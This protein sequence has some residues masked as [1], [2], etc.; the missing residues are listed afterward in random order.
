M[1]PF[2]AAALALL[3]FL[4]VVDSHG[5]EGFSTL[6]GVDLLYEKIVHSTDEKEQVEYARQFAFHC[7]SDMD[8]SINVVL[9]AKLRLL[10]LRSLRKINNT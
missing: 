7:T 8:E 3:F 2:L 4:S 10:L 1:N 5:K 6:L 9:V